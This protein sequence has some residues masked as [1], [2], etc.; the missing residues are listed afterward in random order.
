M[1]AAGSSDAIITAGQKLLV[2]NNGAEILASFTNTEIDSLR[3]IYNL[4][5]PALRSIQDFE[6]LYNEAG[7]S[8][9]SDLP[10]LGVVFGIVFF[11]AA[12]S[13]FF[14]IRARKK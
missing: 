14:I 4:E 6:I 9:K 10:L 5:R 12:G 7:K 3:E 1:A 2:Q 8:G 13:I 11:S